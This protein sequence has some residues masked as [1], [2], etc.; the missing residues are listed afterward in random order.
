V[1]TDCSSIGCSITGLPG[2]AIE[3]VTLSNIHLGLD[4]GGVGED[5]SRQIP[6]KP[7]SYP[8]S[9]MFG[10]LPAYG[11]F[12]RHVKGLRFHNL[13]IETSDADH[14]HAI[15]FDDVDETV[16]DDLD[17]PFASGAAG[18]IRCTNSRNIFIRNCQPPDGTELF[19][20][21]Q[22]PQTDNILLMSN[23][24]SRVEEVAHLAPEVPKSALVLQANL[25]ISSD[26]AIPSK[27]PVP[28][29]TF[30]L[31]ADFPGGNIIVDRIEGDSSGPINATH[32]RGG[33]IGTFGSAVLAAVRSNSSSPAIIPSELRG[34]L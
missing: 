26:K 28:T 9:T 1:A 15:V 6:E 23:D 7:G 24:L 32:S 14:R 4:G 5:A 34:R 25:S 12:C 11:F 30:V 16:L 33:S 3:N 19:L 18:M 29:G 13:Q 20:D 17:A 27:S 21:L 31:D 10:R 22:G 2:H 8:E